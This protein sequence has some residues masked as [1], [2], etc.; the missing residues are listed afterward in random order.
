MTI[1]EVVGRRVAKLRTDLP[2]ALLDT[3]ITVAAYA[4]VFALVRAGGRRFE[5][6]GFGGFLLTASA[7]HLVTN[8]CLRLYGQLW[9][10]ASIAEARRVVVAGVCSGVAL[11]IANGF[12]H[13]LPQAVVVLGCLV[14]TVLSGGVRFQARILS[15]HRRREGR[16]GR[17]VLIVGAG[18]GAN[19]LVRDM[20]AERDPEFVPVAIVDDAPRLRGLQLAG[21]PIDGTVEDLPAVA[22]RRR[23]EMVVLAVPS[24]D[25]RLIERVAAAAE[26]ASLPVKTVPR[27]RDLFGARPSVRDVRDL[28]VEDLLGR[29]E[30]VTDLDA[31][32]RLLSGRTVVITGGGGSIGSEIARQVALF[33]PDRLVLLDNDETHLHDALGTLRYPADLALVDVRDADVVRE[34]FDEIA[35]D[36]VFHAAAL[37]HVPILEDFPAEAVRTNVIG[38]HNVAE[39]AMRA[40]VGRLVFISTDKAVMPTSIMGAS[41]WLAEQIVTATAPPTARWCSVRFGNVLGSRGSVLPTFARQIESGGPV[42]VTDPRMTRFFMSVGEAVQLVLQ[43]AVYA[44]G[45][46]LFMLDMGEPVNILEL[47]ERMIRLSGRAVG[48]EVPIRIVGARPGEKLAEQLR[49][50]YEHP[51]PTDHVSIH[52]LWPVAMSSASLHHAIARLGKLAHANDHQ[53]VERSLRMFVSGGEL[54]EIDLTESS[55]D[56][57]VGDG[58]LGPR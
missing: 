2:L 6:Q 50:Q 44:E 58:S 51:E 33:E 49:A 12:A 1:S 32:R 17:R 36:V 9:R 31:V 18:E 23:A 57:V 20:L 29:D 15:L 10:Y 24:A 41:K 4:T 16:F 39:A 38:T 11:A 22:H 13:W 46:D 47:A 54:D 14:V 21:I 40:G 35:P 42:T 27:V 7:L 19:E 55:G 30:V 25:S 26:I 3:L 5:S 56:R 53:G 43:A 45:R 8:W 48:D 28:R 34:V 52:R 37:K